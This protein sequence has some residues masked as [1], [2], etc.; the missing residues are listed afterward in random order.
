[1]DLKEI[2]KA[3]DAFRRIGYPVKEA[4]ALAFKEG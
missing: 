1:L 2:A 3:Y 4:Y